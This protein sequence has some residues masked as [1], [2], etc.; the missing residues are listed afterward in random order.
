MCY[1]AALGVVGKENRS[2]FRTCARGKDFAGKSSLAQ[3]KLP[4]YRAAQTAGR[5]LFHMESCRERADVMLVSTVLYIWKH[6]GFILNQNFNW[7]I[8]NHAPHLEKFTFLLDWL[9]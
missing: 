7:L 3:S 6:S 9:L 5:S 2:A 4:C 8:F 1:K